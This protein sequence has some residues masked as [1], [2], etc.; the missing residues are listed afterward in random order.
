MEFSDDEQDREIE[1]KQVK[2]NSYVLSLL[3]DKKHL[4]TLL[5]YE[6]E[7]SLKWKSECWDLRE[8]IK[9]LETGQGEPG[10]CS[11]PASTCEERKSDELLEKVAA[12]E[13]KLR[14][15][16]TQINSLEDHKAVLEAEIVRLAESVGKGRSSSD[17]DLA[18]EQLSIYEDDFKKEKNDREKAETQVSVLTDQVLG[19]QDLISRL[20]R[21]V[22]LYKNAFERE[23]RDK[24]MVLMRERNENGF[25]DLPPYTQSELP[26]FCGSPS[27]SVPSPH[28]QVV[29]PVV[30]ERMQQQDIKRKQ[31][32]QRRGVLARDSPDTTDFFCEA[33]FDVNS[34]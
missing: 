4:L 20:T 11:R 5:D 15:S 33:Q 7:V 1:R 22:G 13:I 8:R 32:L 34:L 18:M 27:R 31:E 3:K 6:R 25:L 10:A 9:Q 24:E 26:N 28:L 16:K 19:C 12:L 2:R 23:K 21:E 29:Y 17:V 30:D 14:E